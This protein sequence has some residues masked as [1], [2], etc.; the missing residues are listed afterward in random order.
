MPAANELFAAVSHFEELG[1][2]TPLIGSAEGEAIL[3]SIRTGFYDTRQ[4]RALLVAVVRGFYDSTVFAV[5]S[6]QGVAFAM[7]VTDLI[8]EC[9][10]DQDLCLAPVESVGGV[11]PANY[12]AA[13]RQTLHLCVRTLVPHRALHDEIRVYGED[14][15]LRALLRPADPMSLDYRLCE[16][17]RPDKD[18][19]LDRVVDFQIPGRMSYTGLFFNQIA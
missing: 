3:G 16:L 13:R 15:H 8:E 6:R 12:F 4:G 19:F 2:D 14:E 17:Y 10:S 5:M 9:C 7:R 18:G 11:D 1:D